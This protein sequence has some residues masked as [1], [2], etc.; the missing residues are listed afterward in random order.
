MANIN[1][2]SK[3]ILVLLIIWAGCAPRAPRSD[4]NKDKRTDAENRFE[5]LGFIGDD[6]IIT[7]KNKQTDMPETEEPTDSSAKPA[8]ITG[9]SFD[10]TGI[11]EIEQTVIIFRVQ[12][13]ASKSFDEAQEFA[14][15]IEPLFP[16]GVFVEYQVP[17]YKVRIGEFYDSDEGESFLNEVKDLGF[18]KAWLVRVIQ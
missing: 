9:S 7:G 8:L 5:P 12:I 15:E 17:Y 3:L 18:K 6:E 4:I 10:S 11:A 2:I 13:F 16:E 14:T 1:N